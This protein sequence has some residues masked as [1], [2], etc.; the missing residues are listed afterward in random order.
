MILKRPTTLYTHCPFNACNMRVCGLACK[1]WINARRF[2]NYYVLLFAIFERICV[3]VCP[4]PDPHS[5]IVHTHCVH[6]FSHQVIV[7]TIVASY[8]SF[9]LSSCMPSND[10][11]LSR[12]NDHCWLNGK[13]IGCSR[14]RMCGERVRI[15]KCVRMARTQTAV[16]SIFYDDDWWFS[17]C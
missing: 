10:S 6:T 9:C 12:T 17:K 2:C 7:F 5:Y 16:W 3:H 8:H 13:H 11:K 4:K 15:H 14:E 1:V